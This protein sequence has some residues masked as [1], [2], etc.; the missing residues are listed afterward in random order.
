MVTIIQHDMGWKCSIFLKS[1]YENMSHSLEQ[2]A[3]FDYT[4]H[5]IVINLPEK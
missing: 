2:Q 5:T 1:Y 3:I 4:E